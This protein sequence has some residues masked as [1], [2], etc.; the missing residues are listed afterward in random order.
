MTSDNKTGKGTSS[1]D[2]VDHTNIITTS[3]PI[4]PGA[5]TEATLSVYHTT[6]KIK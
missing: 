2:G 4:N 3:T 5:N 6:F 1:Y